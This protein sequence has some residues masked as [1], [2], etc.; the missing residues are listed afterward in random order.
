MVSHD[1]PMVFSWISHDFPIIFQWFSMVSHHFP[2]V[3][4]HVPMVFHDSPMVLPSFS[5]DFPAV[6]LWENWTKFWRLLLVK[7]KV[8][9]MVPG[10]TRLSLQP[11]AKHQNI[12]IRYGEI[13]IGWLDSNWYIYIYIY[14]YDMIWYDMI[15][16]VYS[17]ICIYIITC[18]YIYIYIYRVLSVQRGS[19]V[20]ALYV[21]H[22]MIG[23]LLGAASRGK[24]TGL[25][26]CR[27]PNDL[28]V[29]LMI[30]L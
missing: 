26:P 14:I 27:I 24:P 21:R 5:R 10:A 17:T 4:H 7:V 6:L 20:W 23:Q 30:T 29:Y 13:R 12:T 16:W 9:Q 15:W 18:M 11:V 2:V 22:A 28:K 1:F 25:K 8:P 3:L 19:L